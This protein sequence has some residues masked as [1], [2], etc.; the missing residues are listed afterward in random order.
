MKLKSGF[1]LRQVA[2][3]HVVLPTGTELDLNVMMTLNDT[4][5]TLWNCLQQ[6]T[7]REAL[8]QALLAEYEV[9]ASTAGDAVDTFLKQLKELD[10]LV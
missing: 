4:G 1:L 8:I 5:A 2:G 7:T 9:D 3:E 10:L 6:E